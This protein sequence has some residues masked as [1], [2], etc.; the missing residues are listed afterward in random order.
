MS[1]SVFA[2]KICRLSLPWLMNHNFQLGLTI[3]FFCLQYF[4]SVEI[5]A[6][7]VLSGKDFRVFLVSRKFIFSQKLTKKVDSR[8]NH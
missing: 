3:A 6:I 5:Q 7:Q 1:L 8:I 2:E 4:I